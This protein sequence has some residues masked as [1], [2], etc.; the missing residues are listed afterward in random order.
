MQTVIYLR[1]GKPLFAEGGTPA[2]MLG[3][4]LVE[5]GRITDAQLSEAVELMTNR[6]VDNEQLQLG[7]AL[8][9]LGFLNASELFETLAEQVRRKLL[10]CFSWRKVRVEYR[11]GA[12]LL[13]GITEFDNA[14]PGLLLEG[15]GQ[16]PP[17]E[18]QRFLERVRTN[19]PVAGAPVREIEQ[20][21][22]L[23]GKERR[24]LDLADGKRSVREIL[25]DAPTE[26]VRTGQLLMALILGRALRLK[27]RPG[28][29]DDQPKSVKGQGS[30]SM[31]GSARLV[32][33]EDLEDEQ[34]EEGWNR[35]KSLFKG[36]IKRGD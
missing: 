7:G 8:V 32:P 5:T 2:D 33:G 18:V 14:V 13:A 24:L 29:V 4:I 31:F 10:T 28:P 6:L 9:E 17:E 15:V 22:R 20:S 27:S 36:A 26:P 19:F 35:V 1:D 21:F 30:S 23:G 16:T 3:R 11:E 25:A 34:E 12:E